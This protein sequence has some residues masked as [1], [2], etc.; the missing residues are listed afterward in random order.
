[1]AIT[2]TAMVDDDGSGKTGTI[3][4]NAWKTELYGQIDAL[5][6]PPVA[7]TVTDAS[8]AGLTFSGP[9][10][11]VRIGNIVSISINITFP[12]T[13][14][15][16]LARLGGL[17]YFSLNAGGLYTIYGIQ[18]VYHIQGNSNSM[19]VFHATT[20]AQ[21]TNADLSGQTVALGGTYQTA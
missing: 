16:S 19:I 6:G 14:N 21:L 2:R 3:I 8:G 1:M 5:I 9:S 15:A 4:N 13:A 7:F 10:G 18:R 12:A 11:Y 20:G 17:P